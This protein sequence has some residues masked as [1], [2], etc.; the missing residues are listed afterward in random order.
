MNDKQS[1]G[2]DE[3][4]ECTLSL[5]DMLIFVLYTSMRTCRAIKKTEGHHPPQS[6][7]RKTSEDFDSND[8]VPGPCKKV[9]FAVNYIQSF[10]MYIDLLHDKLFIILQL[11]SKN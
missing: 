5:F 1:H 10:T 9:K 4:R 6:R 11:R 3:T 8:N 7:K 2:I